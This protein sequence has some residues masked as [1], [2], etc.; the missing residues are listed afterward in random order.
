MQTGCV[1]SAPIQN[2]ATEHSFCCLFRV[3]HEGLSRL[4]KP[5]SNKRW[6]CRNLYGLAGA[7]LSRRDGEV[8]AYT[9]RTG[10][11]GDGTCAVLPYRAD[12]EEMVAGGDFL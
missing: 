3:V 9:R 7:Y 11:R 10:R 4:Q 5:H 2:N 12:S 6:H 1:L 8:R